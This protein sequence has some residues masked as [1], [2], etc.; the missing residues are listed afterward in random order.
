MIVPAQIEQHERIKEIRLR[1]FRPKEIVIALPKTVS[2]V[3]KAIPT[4]ARVWSTR[5]KWRELAKPL[6]GRLRTNCA[7]RIAI[8]HILWT[9]EVTWIDLVGRS[10]L[11]RYKI[12]RHEVIRLVRKTVPALSLPAIGKIFNRDHTTIL[13]VL[14][15]GGTK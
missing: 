13:Y 5:Q 12:P 4:S 7:L 9:H 8:V 15:K 1:M 14:R 11:S 3:E 10:N 6:P 2:Q